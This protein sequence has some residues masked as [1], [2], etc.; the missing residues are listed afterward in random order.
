MTDFNLPATSDDQPP[1]FASPDEC[2]DWLD[3]QPRDQPVQLQAVLLRQLNQLNRFRLSGGERLA[4]MELLREP[5]HATQEDNVRRFA[6]KP[7]PLAP[8][9]Q[10]AFD[11]CLSI[12]S[13]LATG[14]LHCVKACVAHEPGMQMSRALAAQRALAALAALHFDACRGGSLPPAGHWHRLHQAYAVAEEA[15]LTRR[16]V[17]DTLRQGRNPATPLAAWVE[18]LLL[19]AASLHELTPRQMAWAA[20]WAR[21]WAGKVSAHKSP[22]T[23]S[24]RAI[25]LCVDIDTDRPAGYRPVFTPGARFLDTSA[26]R[27]SLKKRVTA[28]EQGELPK[29][30]QLGDDCVQ[31]ACQQLL[32]E[33]YFHWCKGGAIRRNERREVSG[34]CT[35]IGNMEAIHYYLSGRKPFSQPGR[36]ISDTDIRRQRDEIATFGRIM[37]PQLDNYS[38]QQGYQVEEWEVMEEWHMIDQSATGVRITRPAGK[39]GGRFVS[40]Q[41]V[42]V[43]P[44]DA[45]TL[46][47]GTLR[48]VV[49]DAGKSLHGGVEIIAGKPQPVAVRGTGLD[50]V[51][52]K[53]VPAFLLPAMAAL[54]EPQSIVTPPG[55]FKRERVLELLAESPAQIRLTGVIERG[56]DFERS[57]YEKG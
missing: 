45:K 29:N 8:P 32:I 5:V 12:W 42:A 19:Q 47:L 55:F 57:T 43:K 17:S 35:L 4:I 36:S 1:A 3:A 33:M 21:R 38:E 20:R 28:L 10:A 22:P 15:D 54:G 14:Y 34:V 30:L 16:E 51:G 50:A 26:L 49:I 23:M 24:T 7:L 31:P 52:N 9:E 56:S 18:A 53:Y 25:P 48:W 2:S 40:G 13:A 39:S 6:G 37:A 11:A 27:S 46:L 44:A 41:L